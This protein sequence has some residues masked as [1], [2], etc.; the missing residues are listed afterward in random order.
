[1]QFIP[2]R[3]HGII[4]Y[5]L[6]IILIISPWLF[7]FH[8][9]GAKQWVPIVLG[10]ILIA[11]SL[12]TDYEL[13]AVHAIPMPAHL[14]LDVIGGVILI[15]SPWI[16]GFHSTVWVPHV[17]LGIIEIISA[18]LTQRVPSYEKPMRH[19]GLPA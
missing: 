14:V 9:G 2:T 3:I 8:G 16:F 15:I 17:V 4:D 10:I 13:G 1:M 18:I 19:E 7:R 6:G 12:I 5:V 11:Y